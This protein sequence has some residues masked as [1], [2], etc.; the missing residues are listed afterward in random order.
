ME[1]ALK[2]LSLVEATT[3]N[4]VA[5]NVFE[6]S[7]SA[8]ELN[9][10]APDFPAIDDL[11]VTFTRSND[12]SSNEF[13]TAARELGLQV[14]VIPERR[15]FDLTVIPT[16]RR[17]VE[18]ATPHLIVTHSV[19]SHF[20]LW[21][22]RLWQTYPWIAFHHGY[23]TTD[24]KMRAYN[25]LDRWSLPKADRL[26]TVCDA[27]ARELAAITHVPI[28]KIAVQHNSIRP[29]PAPSAK[30]VQNLRSSLGITDDERVML[31]AG[32]LSREKA[33]IDLI[34]AFK[35]LREQNPQL[36]SKLV[37]VGDGPERAKLEGTV[38]SYA[39]ESDVIF[40][41]QQSNVQPFY[42]IADVFVLPSHSE[43]S[44]NVLLEAMAAGVPIIATAVGG[45][46]EMIEDNQSALLVPANDPSALSAAISRLLTD[47]DLAHRLT[48]NASALV[49]N[50]FS[51]EEYVR[52]L[53]EI[54]HQV[55][56]RTNMA[57]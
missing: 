21:R 29:R 47:G 27:F 57:S 14:Q 56:Q 45:V 46:P 37:I 8:Q 49:S 13:L 11:I 40:T 9:E 31:A 28:E 16:L 6:F 3:V 15:R 35:L 42:A 44:S 19:K 34:S 52:S 41:G 48:S 2:I 24:L 36:K 23:T 32:R 26:L 7:Y 50:R 4:A 25:R 55:A 54:Y 18:E 39:L 5:K 30:A 43:G 17:I 1:A 10:K 38:R 12:R 51:P 20:L 22:S 33:H 53:T